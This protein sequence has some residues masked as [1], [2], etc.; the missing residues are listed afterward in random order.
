MRTRSSASRSER[1]SDRPIRRALRTAVLGLTLATVAAPLAAQQLPPPN[2]NA[3]LVLSRER[4]LA[5]AAVG[6]RL[7]DLEADMT[8]ELQAQ[9]DAVKARLAAEE[10]ELARLRDTLPRE[11][12]DRRV[13]SFDQTVRR[14]RR[15]TQRRA[16][17]LQTAFRQARARLVDALLPIL[18]AISR[19]K[20][21]ALVLDSK[22]ILLAH[23]SLDIT[24][25]VIAMYDVRVPMPELPALDALTAPDEAPEAP[26]VGTDPP[27]ETTLPS[28][29]APAGAAPQ[30]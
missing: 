24:D 21:A 25:E 20:G 18:V 7:N 4:V 23:P 27:A 2:T 22:Q 3:I 11:E 17:A 14:E 15:E 9:V 1:G 12:F 10:Q 28:E 16:A 26:A 8:A 5:E 30:Q 13:Q 6:K 29:P 19:E